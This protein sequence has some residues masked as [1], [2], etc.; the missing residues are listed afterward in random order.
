MRTVVLGKLQCHCYRP[1]VSPIGDLGANSVTNL[2][3]QALSDVGIDTAF[4]VSH[5]NFAVQEYTLTMGW[6]AVDS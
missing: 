2:I 6:D 4:P 5:F 1:T 3:P